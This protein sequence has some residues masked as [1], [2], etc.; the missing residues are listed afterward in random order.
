MVMIDSR[1]NDLEPIERA[2]I[3]ARIASVQG[4]A[5]KMPISS[6]Q[7]R[8]SSPWRANSSA[9]ASMYDGVTMMMRG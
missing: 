3:D 4:S 9:M 7:A 8:A 1:G 2:S 6:E 5:P